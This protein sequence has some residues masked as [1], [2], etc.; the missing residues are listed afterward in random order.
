MPKIKMW[1]PTRR[2]D[3]LGSQ[4]VRLQIELADKMRYAARLEV[5]LRTRT[6]RIDELTGT[7]ERLREQN[8][9]LDQEAERY[10]EMIRLS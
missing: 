1:E 10:A 9:R 2:R 4:L 7:V 8:R 3:A 5:L 6:K